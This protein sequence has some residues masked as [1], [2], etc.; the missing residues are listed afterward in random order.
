MAAVRAN[1][2]SRLQ[3][4]SR[5]VPS[6]LDRGIEASPL[7]SVVQTPPSIFS[8][9]QRS[10]FQILSGF[11]LDVPRFDIL[12]RRVT[13]SKFLAR[14]VRLSKTLPKPGKVPSGRRGGL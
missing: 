7:P 3:M 12:A 13:R 9:A 10:W 5:Q 4:S 1:T 8:S 11:A 14:L 6:P 2:S